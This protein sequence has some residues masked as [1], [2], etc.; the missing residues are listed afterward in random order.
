MSCGVGR[1]GSLDLVLLWLWY[2]PAAVAPIRP[3]VWEPPFAAG[4]ALK[5]KE[6]KK[7]KKKWVKE[8]NRPLPREDIEMSSK[9]L[10]ECSITYIIR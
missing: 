9:H 5:Q 1:R 3:L 6:K 8:L 2:R 4:A 10:K 7:K